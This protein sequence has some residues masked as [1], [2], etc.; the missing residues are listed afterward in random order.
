MDSAPHYRAPAE[1]GK[2]SS[3]GSAG[4]DNEPPRGVPNRT[5]AALLTLLFGSGLGHFY[6]GH[7]QR[8]VLWATVPPTLFGLSCLML[9]HLSAQTGYRVF[10]LGAL[11]LLPT[12]VI[13]LIDVLR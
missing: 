13:A 3:K 8:G 7:R 10:M 2:P 9:P 6:L 11:A 4:G 5:L 12:R 1:G